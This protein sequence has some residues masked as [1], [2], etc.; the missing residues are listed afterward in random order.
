VKEQVGFNLGAERL[1]PVNPKFL[2]FR[3]SSP[4]VLREFS[5]SNIRQCPQDSIVHSCRQAPSQPA[6]ILS[7]SILEEQNS[8]LR[9]KGGKANWFRVR[10]CTSTECLYLGCFLP[11]QLK[12][13]CRMSLE[14]TSCFLPDFLPHPSKKGTSTK[15]TDRVVSKQ[16]QMKAVSSW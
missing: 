8:A 9:A 6:W 7:T 14:I 2:K 13:P 12:A 11:T 5:P 4:N 16:E 15:Q 1:T 10:S 3:T